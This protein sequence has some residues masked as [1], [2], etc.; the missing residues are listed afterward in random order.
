MHATFFKNRT[1]LRQISD[2][3]PFGGTKGFEDSYLRCVFRYFKVSRF[4]AKLLDAAV[5]A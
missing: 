1:S 3:F 2:C 4:Y 5:T